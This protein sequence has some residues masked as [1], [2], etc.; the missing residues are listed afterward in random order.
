MDMMDERCVREDWGGMGTTGREREM[1]VGLRS[2]VNGLDQMCHIR[3]T[4]KH[5]TCQVVTHRGLSEEDSLRDHVT[6]HSLV[7]GLDE[8]SHILLVVESQQDFRH[9]SDDGDITWAK[10]HSFKS[11]SQ[12]VVTERRAVPA[13]VQLKKVLIYHNPNKQTRPFIQP[14]SEPLKK[15]QPQPRLQHIRAFSTTDGP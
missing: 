15:H 5:T 3:S 11:S 4:H 12:Q 8:M 10:K 7:D 13:Q 2:F 6:S 1:G 14:Y 9:T